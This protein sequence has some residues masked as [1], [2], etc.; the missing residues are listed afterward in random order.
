MNERRSRGEGQIR[1]RGANLQLRYYRNGL[2]IEESTKFADTEEGRKKAAKL[3]RQRLG[4]LAAGIAHDSRSIRYEGL[5]EAYLTEYRL[6]GRKSLRFDKAGNPY[7]DKV[8]RLDDFFA[9]YR[10][11]E[12]DADLIRKFIGDQQSKGLS[13]GSI[14]RSVSALRR[15][16]NLAVEDGRLRNVPHFPTLRESAPRQG[17]FERDQYESLRAALPDYL[18]LPLAI[19]F[20]TGMREGEILGLKWDQIDW[21]GNSI[22]LRAGETKNDEGRTIPIISTLKELL[23]AQHSR[24]NADCPYVCF[25]LDSKRHAVKIRGFRKAWYGACV[26]SGLGKWEPAV[27]AATGEPIYDKPSGPRSKPKMK[28]VYNGRLFHDLRRSGVRNLV[29]AGVPE[30]VAMTISGHKTRS[31]FERYNIVSERDLSEAARKL[32]DFHKNG[33]NSGTVSTD[34]QQASVPTI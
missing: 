13:N 12:I 7:L 26:K 5:R 20:F 30:R 32:A 23:L 6:N 14:N 11:I 8:N 34:M 25:R 1:A 10:V 28:M 4:E 21:L 19:G 27:N 3:L 16:F 29:R 17:F 2:R 15:M 9:G 31:V 24:K 22:N 33:D 18:R